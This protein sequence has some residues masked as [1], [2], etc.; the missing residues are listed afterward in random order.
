MLLGM[1]VSIAVGQ[2]LFLL[3]LVGMFVLILLVQQY[4]SKTAV[5]LKD[6]DA[7]TRSPQLNQLEEAIDGMVTVRSFGAQRMMLRRFFH[8]ANVNT[9]CNFL[10]FVTQGWL[11]TYLGLLGAAV[12]TGAALSAVSSRLTTNPSVIITGLT[13]MMGI[14]NG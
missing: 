2:P 13:M 7:L 8:T 5:A 3:A 9:S 4:Y 10:M 14:P 6:L 11:V 12:T 1:G